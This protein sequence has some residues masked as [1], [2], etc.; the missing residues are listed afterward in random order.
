MFVH[1]I[2]QDLKLQ[3]LYSLSKVKYFSIQSDGSTDSGKNEEKDFFIK[4]FDPCLGEKQVCIKKI[5]LMLGSLSILL[6][7]CC[8]SA[9]KMQF[10]T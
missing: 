2:A 4:Y 3:L 1:Y 8:F 6:S 7:W 10:V 5:F 9:W